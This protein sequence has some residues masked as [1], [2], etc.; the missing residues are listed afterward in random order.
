LNLR[1]NYKYT[2]ISTQTTTIVDA[3]GSGQ[4]V[5]II[6]GETAAGAITIYNEAAGGTTNVIGVLKASIPEGTYEFGV[7]YSVGL[8]IVTAA[9]SKLIV[10]TNPNN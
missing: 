7:N 1:D 9:A 10:V 8:Q 3:A 6:L 4:L 5:R 2:Y